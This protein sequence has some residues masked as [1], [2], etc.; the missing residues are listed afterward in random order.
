[1]QKA[2][3]AQKARE[4]QKAPRGAALGL[5]PERQTA[6]K[7]QKVVVLGLERQTARKARKARKAQKEKN[8]ALFGF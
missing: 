2:A 7:A 6:Q 1:M 8:A 4:A 5:G 3:A